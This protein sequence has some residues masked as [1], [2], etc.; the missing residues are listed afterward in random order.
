[1]EHILIMYV[2]YIDYIWNIYGKNICS[3]YKNNICCPE[4]FRVWTYMFM[5]SPPSQNKQIKMRLGGR[6][7][8]LHSA[9]FSQ[10]MDTFT[11]HFRLYGINLPLRD[12]THC[13]LTSV[14]GWPDVLSNWWLTPV[15]TWRA[16]SPLK[17]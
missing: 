10:H 6:W 5:N 3:I 14:M 12:H 9:A 13:C 1:M 2:A 8:L 17:L 4:F 15:A 16:T 11:D 7:I